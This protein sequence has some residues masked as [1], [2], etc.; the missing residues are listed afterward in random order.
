MNYNEAVGCGTMVGI[1][2]GKNYGGGSIIPG[3][4]IQ[5]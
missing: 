3:K 2:V 1:Q 4:C 5:N